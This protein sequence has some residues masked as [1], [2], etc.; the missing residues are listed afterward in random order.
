MLFGY[1]IEAT[2]ENWFHDC[3]LEII[4]TINTNTRQHTQVP[5]WP[6]IIPEAHRE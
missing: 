4:S 6:D 1:P 2:E 5:P 3:I